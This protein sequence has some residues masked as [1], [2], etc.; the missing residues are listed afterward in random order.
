MQ[1]QAFH[2]QRPQATAATGFPQPCGRRSLQP[3]A[4]H[5]RQV[6]GTEDPLAAETF[7]LLKAR[8]DFPGNCKSRAL[9][10]VLTTAAARWRQRVWV[11]EVPSSTC[12]FLVGLRACCSSLFGHRPSVTP[13]G[14]RRSLL[15]PRSSSAV[16]L[17][18]C[19]HGWTPGCIAALSRGVQ[20]PAGRT[21]TI[22]DGSLLLQR[23]AAPSPWP[24]FV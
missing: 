24:L 19:E 16:R 21:C 9:S 20:H 12:V 5:G 4:F 6:A 3:Q 13:P 7:L 14:S 23:G 2:N 22:A 1:L 11:T 10:R 15:F 8:G 18:V 17:G